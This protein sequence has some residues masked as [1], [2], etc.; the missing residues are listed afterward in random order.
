MTEQGNLIAFR[1]FIARLTSD[2]K[3]TIRFN[4]IETKRGYFS[5]LALSFLLTRRWYKGFLK[6]KKIEKSMVDWNLNIKVKPKEFKISDS[7]ISCQALPVG[8][9]KE[10]QLEFSL[11]ALKNVNSEGIHFLSG[12]IDEKRPLYRDLFYSQ[13]TIKLHDIQL[14]DEEIV[15]AWVLYKPSLLR[16]RINLN[17]VMAREGFCEINPISRKIHELEIFRFYSDL[18]DA[19]RHAKTFSLG[20]YSDTKSEFIVNQIPTESSFSRMI[21]NLKRA[22]T[23][24]RYERQLYD[25]IGK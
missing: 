1:I 4:F 17:I 16:R 24:N 25:N 2:T 11:A 22:V 7:R 12:L 9:S 8:L 6:G 13:F 20:V 14:L 18:L 10:T 19:N 15:F 21:K 5:F 3:N 23:A